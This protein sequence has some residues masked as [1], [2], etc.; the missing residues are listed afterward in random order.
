MAGEAGLLKAAGISGIA[1][2]VPGV[3]AAFPGAFDYLTLELLDEPGADLGPALSQLLPF[4]KKHKG[5]LIHCNAGIS[6]APSLAIAWLILE[7]G[8]DLDAALELLQSRRPV[9]PNAGF[10]AQLR[11]LEAGRTELAF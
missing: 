1:C 10:M 6:R 7:E 3:P 2:A 4:I 5:V 8:M 9:K 11:Q